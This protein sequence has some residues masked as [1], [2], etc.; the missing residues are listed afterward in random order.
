MS[1]SVGSILLSYIMQRARQDGKKL[2]AHFKQTDRNRMMYVTYRFSNFSE[3]TNDGH[4][5][6]VFAN[7]LSQVQGFPPYVEVMT[8][9]AAGFPHSQA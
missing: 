6:I 1:R 8:P 7:D 9:G 3:L 5:N 2:L 4:G